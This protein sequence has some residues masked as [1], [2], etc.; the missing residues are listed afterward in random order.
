MR[1]GVTTHLVLAPAE[2][3]TDLDEWYGRLDAVVAMSDDARW[4][5][6]HHGIAADLPED[7]A[8][9][10]LLKARG[11]LGEA[12]EVRSGEATPTVLVTDAAG[13]R[14]IDE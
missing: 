11:A 8:E 2:G 3:V 12:L 4:H 1:E 13:G 6:E 14:P 5:C 10:V 7:E 9:R